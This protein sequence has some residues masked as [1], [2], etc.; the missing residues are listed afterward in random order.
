MKKADKNRCHCGSYLLVQETDK[1]I[2]RWT[3]YEMVK[4]EKNGEGNGDAGGGEVQVQIVCLET[5]SLSR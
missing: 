2:V 5:A 4:A 3:L 1:N